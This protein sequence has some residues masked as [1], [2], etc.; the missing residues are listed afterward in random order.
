[1]KKYHEIIETPLP[2]SIIV[3]LTTL[4]RF[5]PFFGSFITESH[6]FRRITAVI[7]RNKAI[8]RITVCKFYDCGSDHHNI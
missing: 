7:G 6:A 4:L 1:M 8:D 5:L 3:K 2:F